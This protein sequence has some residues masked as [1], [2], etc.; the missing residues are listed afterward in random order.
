MLG[1]GC[2]AD[3]VFSL[4]FGLKASSLW[5]QLGDCPAPIRVRVLSQRRASPGQ[6]ALTDSDTSAIILEVDVFKVLWKDLIVRPGDA[7]AGGWGEGFF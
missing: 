4:V 5:S 2:Q 3:V 6:S 7:I 1:K